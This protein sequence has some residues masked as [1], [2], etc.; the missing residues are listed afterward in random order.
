MKKK[1]GS[2][3][4]K[5]GIC[6]LQ[7]T[8]EVRKHKNTERRNSKIKGDTKKKI[9]KVLVWREKQGHEYK[10]QRVPKNYC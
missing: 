5:H 1:K 6:R 3:Y 9:L 7:E 2:G 10:L 4:W 8:W